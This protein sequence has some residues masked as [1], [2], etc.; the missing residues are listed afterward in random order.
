[1]E[2]EKFHEK[3]EAEWEKMMIKQIKDAEED[4]FWATDD[5]TGM[6]FEGGKVVEARA[7][8]VEYIRAKQVWKK[9]KRSEALRRGWKIIKTRWLDINK[10]DDEDP[11][12]RSRLVGKEFSA[13][14]GMDGILAGTP[15]LEA[16]IY[17]I[18]DAASVR[19]GEVGGEKVVLVADVARAFF[20]AQA[21]RN[22]CVELPEEDKTLEDIH[23][24]RVGWL[25][26]SLYGTRDAARNWQEEV[27]RQMKKWGFRRGVYNPCLY[28]S[29]RTIKYKCWYM[30]TILWLWQRER[31]SEN[32]RSS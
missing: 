26:M 20:E 18:H 19:E 21:T 14:D 9:I 22:I 27:A 17:A 16:L 2:V 6:R 15:P 10:G 28:S 13:K 23:E 7:K 29:K 12:Y 32:S 25:Q 30:E 8:E 31:Q 3:E 24:D 11:I 4:R 1:M 5:L